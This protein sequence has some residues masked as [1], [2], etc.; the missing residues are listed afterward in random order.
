MGAWE[1]Q[2]PSVWKLDSRPE[3]CLFV[4][5]FVCFFSAPRSTNAG[6]KSQSS[7]CGATLGNDVCKLSRNGHYRGLNSERFNWLVNRNRCETSCM[8][9]CDVCY[10][11]KC[12]QRS[13]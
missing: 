4:C 6:K 10:T 13:L 5:L 3:C 12:S 7:E 8:N 9:H 1:I 11:G 2:A